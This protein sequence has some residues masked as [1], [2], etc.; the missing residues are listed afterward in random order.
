M[1]KKLFL[2][3]LF[4]F[5]A[6][7]THAQSSSFSIKATAVVMENL[8]M[9]TI[10]DMDLVSPAI[11]ENAITVSP[12]TSTY[13]GLFKILGSPNARVQ[14][15]YTPRETLVEQNEGVGLVQ[16]VYSLSAAP[17]DNQSASFLLTQ[18]NAD[19]TIGPMGE[20]F[21]WL[22]AELDVSQATQGNYVSEFV[23][24]FEYM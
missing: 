5:L 13:A 22:G 1:S 15:N 19:V 16:A 24:E 10:R 3:L 20:V 2:I 11:V 17:E 23:I 18:G 6:L 21:I 7:Q 12:I 9:I 14:I 8:Q 4:G